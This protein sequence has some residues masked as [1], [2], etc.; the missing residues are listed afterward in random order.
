MAI[1][2]PA[3]QRDFLWRLSHES[4]IRS[5]AGRRE[6]SRLYP[7]RPLSAAHWASGDCSRSTR[8][9]ARNRMRG[10]AGH[11]SR[12]LEKESPALQGWSSWSLIRLLGKHGLFLRAVHE[13]NVLV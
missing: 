11:G 8:H 7:G 5:T 1:V 12:L 4:K 3:A 10:A 2:L 9:R 6:A 13:A